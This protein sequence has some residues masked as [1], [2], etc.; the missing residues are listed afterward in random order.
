MMRYP[1]STRVLRAFGVF[2]E[3]IKNDIEL[4]QMA[5]RTADEYEEEAFKLKKK[6]HKNPDFSEKAFHKEKKPVKSAL[7]NN[8]VHPFDAPNIDLV[9]S[10]SVISEKFSLKIHM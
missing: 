7:K 8:M 3:E 5:F 2:L 1:K 9:K 10:S 4:S 6:K